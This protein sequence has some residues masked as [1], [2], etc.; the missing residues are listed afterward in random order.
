MPTVPPGP[1]PDVAAAPPPNLREQSLPEPVIE[2]YEVEVI[3]LESLELE[4]REPLLMPSE[5]G[6]SPSVERSRTQSTTR[7]DPDNAASVVDLDSAPLPTLPQD[8]P[9]GQDDAGPRGRPH[10]FSDS[11][12]TNEDYDGID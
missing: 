5:N 7:R 3:D 2:G 9:D 10:T 1:L 8:R 11:L 12:I 4:P 6:P